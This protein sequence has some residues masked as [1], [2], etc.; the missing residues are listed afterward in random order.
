VI[1]WL[2][3]VALGATLTCPV[4]L[5]HGH[6]VAEIC[7]VIAS[8]CFL[9]R[10][11]AEREWGWLGTTWMKIGL[12][13]WGWQ[14]ICSVPGLFVILGEGGMRSFIQAIVTIRFLIFVAALEHWVLRNHRARRWLQNVISAC[15]IYISA[16]VLLQFGTGHNLYGAPRHGDGELTGPFTKPR[17]AAPL[18]RMLFPALLPPVVRLLERKT[19]LGT[20]E[21]GGLVLAAMAVMVLIG[22]RMPLLLTLFGLL[23]SGLLLPRVRLV[24]A[25]GIVAAMLLVGASVVISPPTFYRLV[26]KFS[27]QME[28]FPESPYGLIAARAVTIAEQH[29]W[30]GRGFD[31]FRSGCRLPRYFEGWTYPRNPADTGGGADICMQHPHNHYLE[32]VTNGGVPGLLLFCA[33]VLAWLAPMWRGL[34]RNPDPLLLGLFVAALI[35]EWP[36]AS[37][38]G[39]TS[40]PMGGWFF[41]LLG[42][43]LAEARHMA[44]PAARSYISPESTQPIRQ[45]GNDRHARV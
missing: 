13:W 22:Q 17:A 16:Q 12:V 38:S 19:W 9:V 10:S 29:P 35:S 45:S 30:T 26:E 24:F 37:T 4:F 18:S 28:H 5:M 20:A 44:D 1:R 8:V 11:A 32:E 3:R 14:V 2:D 7:M 36:I 40:M 33:L 31:G 39:F 34:R 15:T 23:V 41:L 25:G 42:Y 27:S 43:G 21:A 6:A